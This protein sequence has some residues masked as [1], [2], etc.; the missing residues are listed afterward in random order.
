MKYILL[1]ILIALILGCLLAL[2]TP[3]NNEEQISQKRTKCCATSSIKP[4]QEIL[5]ELQLL[6]EDLWTK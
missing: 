1:Y 6:D 4:K 3:N 2:A 5:D